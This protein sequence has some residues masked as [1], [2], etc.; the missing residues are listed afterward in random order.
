MI[1]IKVGFFV[2]QYV[3]SWYPPK[4]IM[5]VPMEHFQ[6]KQN[7]NCFLLPKFKHSWK[8][9]GVVALDCPIRIFGPKGTI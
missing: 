3:A 9:V 4:I 1:F 5:K 2:V 7:M 8:F 6:L